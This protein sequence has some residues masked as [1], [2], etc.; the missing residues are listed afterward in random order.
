MRKAGDTIMRSLTML[1]VIPVQPHSKTTRE[2]GEELLA[3]DPTYEVDI[4]SIQR[5]LERLSSI[6]P[7]ASER[8]GRANRWFWTQKDAITQI[9][10]MSRETAFALKLAG[11]YLKPIMPPS[12]LRLLD[13]HLRSADEMLKGE[14]KLGAWARKVRIVERGL[15]MTPPSVRQDV[16]EEVYRALLDD[17]CIEVTISAPGER[18]MR[19]VLNPLGVVFRGGIVHLVATE[20]DE[21]GERG[22][23]VR[24]FV[25]H[26][27][28]NPTVLAEPAVRPRGFSLSRHIEQTDE[29]SAEPGTVKLKLRALF[30]QEAVSQLGDAKLASDHRATRRRDGRTLVQATVADSAELRTWLMGFGAMVEVLSPKRLRGELAEHAA[31]LHSAYSGK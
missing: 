22:T 16:I 5:S 29:F 17:H 7:I 11:E 6:F 13:G 30:Q 21:E 23:D 3:V 4:R 27:M 12:T 19:R 25:L 28:S 8:H 9:P 24:H 1:R 14:S 2:I 31:A 18:A 20:S 15:A 10:A 26:R